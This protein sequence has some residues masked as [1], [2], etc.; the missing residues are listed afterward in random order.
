M[1][2][3]RELPEE[4]VHHASKLP[5]NE[6]AEVGEVAAATVAP[7]PALFGR[8][9][10]VDER[11]PELAFNEGVAVAPTLALVTLQM[12]KTFNSSSPS[13]IQLSA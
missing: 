2:G 5:L 11:L 9:W 13:L 1:R 10:V 7:V 3:G 12:Q 8:H 6:D 4:V